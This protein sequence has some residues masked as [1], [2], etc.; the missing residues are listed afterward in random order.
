LQQK[1]NK[2]KEA[3]AYSYL[4]LNDSYNNKHREIQEL[5]DFAKNLYAENKNYNNVVTLYEQIYS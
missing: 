2:E 1:L 5:V 3:L 4:I